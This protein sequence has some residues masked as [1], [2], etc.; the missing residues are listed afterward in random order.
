MI[1]L[2]MRLEIQK[3]SLRL[4]LLVACVLWGTTSRAAPPP[5][6]DQPIPQCFGVSVHFKDQGIEDND[7]WLQ[8]AGFG[9]VRRDLFWDNVETR[10]GVY[11]FTAYDKMLDVLAAHNMRVMF[12]L[13]YA[14]PLYDAGLSPHSTEGRAAFAEKRDPVFKGE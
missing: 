7:A 9:W 13:D 4:C 1:D 10:K 11:D 5:L 12:I 2:R 8:K 6:P 14:N 3:K